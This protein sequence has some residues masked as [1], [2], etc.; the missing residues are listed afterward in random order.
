MSLTNLIKGN[1]VPI[2]E[3]IRLE[4]L[5]FGTFGVLKINKQVFCWTLEPEDRL[6][7]VG[8]SSIDPQQ[9]RCKRYHSEKYGECFK[10]VDVTGRTAILIHWLNIEDDTEGCIGLGDSIGFVKNKKAILNSKRTFA[11]FMSIMEDIDEFILSISES[12]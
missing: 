4:E 12:Y 7:A 10:V 11:L 5:R 9:Y 1:L 3:V 2:V 6:N 8:I